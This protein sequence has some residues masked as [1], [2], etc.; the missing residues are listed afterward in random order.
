MTYR[1]ETRRF[2]LIVSSLYPNM[3][4]AS[5]LLILLH[6]PI[7]VFS[8][9][10]TCLQGYCCK[11]RHQLMTISTERVTWYQCCS[12]LSAQWLFDAWAS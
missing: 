10:S 7:C 8:E 2:N 1:V 12:L 6:R 9:V 3:P 4:N 11:W 5:V